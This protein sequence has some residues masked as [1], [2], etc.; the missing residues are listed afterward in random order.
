MWLAWAGL[1]AS[2]LLARCGVG[3]GGS[4]PPLRDVAAAPLPAGL[5]L[6]T[7]ASGLEVPWDVGFAPD[8][9]IFVTERP[10]RVRVVEKGVLRAAPWAEIPVARTGET[11]LTAL[12]VDP[13][14]ART[15]AVY[16]LAT[17]RTAAGLENRVL[18]LT[19]RGGRGTE[20]RVV[21]SGLPANRYHAGSALDFGPDG[22]LYVTVGD[23]G[24]PR[25]SQDPAS[26][27]GKLLRYRPDGSV[28]PDNPIRGSPVYARGLRNVQGLDWDPASGALFAGDHGPSGF[29]NEWFRRGGDE[30]NVVV[31]DGN[32]GWPI[33][34]GRSRDRR[35]IAPLSEWTPAIAP[36]GIAVYTGAGVPEWRGSV[37]MGALRGRQLRRV[38]V[39]RAAGE[40][41]GWRTV[42]EEALFAGR[43][44]R[45]RAVKMGPDG[46]LY[47]TTSNRDGRGDPGPGDDHLLRI[48]R[49][50]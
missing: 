41:S 9:R 31:R 11:G 47:F 15:G 13:D 33:V 36:A 35:F 3:P 10:G 17:F 37:F 42:R 34:S 39:E 49:K 29:P 4:G 26:L 30:L 2:T 43:L 12:A 18:R 40:R 23:A 48:I 6:D 21:V 32:Y 7:V 50:P 28:P 8:G 19:D 46:A 20:M 24:K 22:M 16:L 44:G 5:T 45:I 1:L 38:E 27:A 25:R 14:F